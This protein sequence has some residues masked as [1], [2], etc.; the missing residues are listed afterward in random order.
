MILL[1]LLG[2][3]NFGLTDRLGRTPGDEEVAG[4]L[5]IEGVDPSWGP[6]D[7]ETEVTITGTGMDGATAVF[8]GRSEVPLTRIDA[9]TIVATAPAYGMEGSVD[10]RV[11][12]EDAEDELEG[13]FTYAEEAPEET[14]ADTDADSDSD[15]DVDN[16][17]KTGGLVQLS[18]LQIACPDC[19]GLTSSLDVSAQAGFHDPVSR[20]WLDWLPAEG[21]CVTDPSVT[22]PTESFLDAG[23]WM[24]LTSGSR[25]LGLR[26]ADGVYS[27]TGLDEAD[28]VRNAAYDL[29]APAGGADVDSFSVIDALTTPQAISSL[30]PMEILYTTPRD[31]FTARISRSGASFTWSPS[32]GGGTFLVVLSVYNSQGTASLGEVTCRGA[33]NGRMTVPSSAIGAFPTGSLVLVGM[34]RYT[35]GSFER[36]DDRSRVDTV[37]SFGVLGTGSLTP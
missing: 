8:F 11:V 3:G 14:D 21:G 27:A 4:A 15:A 30:T 20:G 2:C 1:A 22:P 25:S 28:F 5:Q 16:S 31:A 7:A 33:D 23:E 29:S 17:D 13:G 26:N 34:Y 12:G 32:G 36:P 37:A 35:I 10:V 9:N 24:Y 19:V 18:L 6:P